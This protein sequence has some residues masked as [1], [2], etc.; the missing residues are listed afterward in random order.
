MREKIGPSLIVGI[1]GT[2]LASEEAAFLIRENIGGIILF[3]RNFESPRQLFDLSTELRS[4]AK[5]KGDKTPFFISVDQ[6]GGR[7]A[8]FRAPFTEW[9]PMG[10]VGKL[11]SA[12]VAFKVA[13]VL[14]QELS[15]VG[16]NLNFAPSVDVFTNPQNTVIGDRSL[17]SDPEIVAK[18]GSALVR[19]MIKGGVIPVAK[20][21]PGHGNT[22]I[23]SHE[24]LPIENKTLEELDKCELEPFKKVF[25]AR[26][27]V[28]MSSHLLFPKIDPK[29]PVSLSEIFLKNILRDQLRY[30]GLIISDDLDMKALTKHHAKGDI[31]VRALQAGSNILCYCNEPDSPAIAIDAIE[32]AVRDKVLP[33]QLLQDN[34]ARIL[35]LKTDSGFDT[36]PLVWSESEKLIGASAHRALSDAVRAGAVPASLLE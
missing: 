11:D 5:R 35:A 30:R 24:E 12:T 17:S 34:A 25:R 29:W 7:V 2:S 19:G 4:V 23:D 26:L 32:K 13:Q 33:L 36:T 18:L 20:H 8:R 28:V 31:A 9:P 10:T 6:E 16:I 22:L 15:A 1:Q 27:S 3:K 14:A 21:F